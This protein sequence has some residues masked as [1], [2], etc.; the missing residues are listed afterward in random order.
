M[1]ITEDIYG[2]KVDLAMTAWPIPVAVHI[3]A[4]I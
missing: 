4:G 3:E 1:E 2:I